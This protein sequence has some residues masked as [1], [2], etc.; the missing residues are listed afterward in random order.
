MW[1]L[2]KYMNARNNATD[3]SFSHTSLYEQD[4]EQ[5]QMCTAALKIFIA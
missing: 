2:H 4:L 1:S 3:F 5:A